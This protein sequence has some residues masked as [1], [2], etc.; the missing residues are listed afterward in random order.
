MESYK[1]DIDLHPHVNL[2]YKT[3][4]FATSIARLRELSQEFSSFMEN[5]M[6][7]SNGKLVDKINEEIKRKLD[8]QHRFIDECDIDFS[9]MA[10]Q[11]MDHINDIRT[12]SVTIYYELKKIETK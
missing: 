6:K 5:E 9:N 10:S 4:S 8:A 11:Y 2:H 3:N 7:H 12:Q 1:M